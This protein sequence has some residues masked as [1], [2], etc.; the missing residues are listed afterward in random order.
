MAPGLTSSFTGSWHL[1]LRHWVA[2]S[3][4]RQAESSSLSCG[5]L[6]RH[7]VAS[8][9]SSRRRSYLRLR[10]PDQAPTRT[11]TSLT[12]CAQERTTPL[13]LEAGCSVP[14]FLRKRDDWR[15]ARSPSGPYWARSTV[16]RPSEVAEAVRS[17]RGPRGPNR[18][19]CFDELPYARASAL[20]VR[21]LLYLPSVNNRPSGRLQ[22]AVVSARFSSTLSAA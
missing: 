9:L 22:K 4:R 1:G 6:I 8:H 17:V 20:G 21:K 18:L 16:A 3:P 10:G 12:R 15:S 19:P 2:G 11:F 14:R 13:P 5:L 7:P